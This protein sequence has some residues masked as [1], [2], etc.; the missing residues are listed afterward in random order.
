MGRAVVGEGELARHFGRA[1][2]R[3]W[4]TFEAGVE[5]VVLAGEGGCVRWKKGRASWR[6]MLAGRGCGGG[7]FL[8]RV[9][10][11]LF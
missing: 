11:G 10:K 1:G 7:A 9:W 5:R 3:G 6:A 2:M 4:S 8:K